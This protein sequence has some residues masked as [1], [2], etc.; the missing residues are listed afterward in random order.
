MHPP[1]I[2]AEMEPALIQRRLVL[3]LALLVACQQAASW[4]ASPD[5]EQGRGAESWGGFGFCAHVSFSLPATETNA[6]LKRG[7]RYSC[8]QSWW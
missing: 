1:P 5:G 2:F 8:G 4:S 7:P 3:C 6:P